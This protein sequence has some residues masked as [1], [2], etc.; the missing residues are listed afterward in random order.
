M[1]DADRRRRMRSLRQA[2]LGYGTR[3]WL[4]DLLGSETA[5]AARWA[6]NDPSLS[7]VAALQAASGAGRS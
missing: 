3:Q 4:D 1:P 5:D 2:V 7:P 6:W